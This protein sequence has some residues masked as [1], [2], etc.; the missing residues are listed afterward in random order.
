MD[1]Q[2]TQ[3]VLLAYS[4]VGTVDAGSC[5]CAHIVNNISH[6]VNNFYFRFSRT[7]L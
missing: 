4:F 2:L 3:I 7:V 6:T 5:L 1:V